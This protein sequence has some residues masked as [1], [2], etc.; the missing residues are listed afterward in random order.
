[1]ME[2]GAPVQFLKYGERLRE[3]SSFAKYS[4]EAVKA[5]GRVSRTAGRTRDMDSSDETLVDEDNAEELVEHLAERGK[6]E[7]G[8]RDRLDII[9][10]ISN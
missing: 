10:R 5:M 2:L 3:R 8:F 4:R 9:A 6:S 7:G 1:M